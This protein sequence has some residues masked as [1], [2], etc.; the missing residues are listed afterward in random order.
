LE[1]TVS[2][3]LNDLSNWHHT[4]D[5]LCPVAIKS[6]LYEVAEQVIMHF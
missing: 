6:S 2:I 5:L 4:F 3:V 1:I